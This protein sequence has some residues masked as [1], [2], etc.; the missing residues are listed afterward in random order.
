MLIGILFILFSFV[1]LIL[2]SLK[3]ILL[4]LCIGLG[5]A[6]IIADLASGYELRK[7]NQLIKKRTG[8][9]YVESFA[10][11]QGLGLAHMQEVHLLVFSDGRVEFASFSG[12]TGRCLRDNYK[13]VYLDALNVNYLK[14]KFNCTD[15]PHDFSIHLSTIINYINE[16]TRFSFNG[17]LLLLQ[18]EE[19]DAIYT[20]ALRP[21]ERRSQMAKVEALRGNYVS[22][23]KKEGI[24]AF[25]KSEKMGNINLD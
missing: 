3:P 20:I 13:I 17:L 22:F 23:D 24:A 11:I 4:L 19:T 2:G 8:A 9:A 15:I 6:I 25:L 21:L 1:L 14:H 10:H 5:L 18:Y 7:K 12:S 16:S